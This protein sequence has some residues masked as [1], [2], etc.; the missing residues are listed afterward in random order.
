MKKILLTIPF[1]LTFSNAL[2]ISKS[3][4]FTINSPSKNMNSN[5]SLDYNAKTSE[6]IET[7]FKK[8]IDIVKKGKICK[9]GKYSIYPNYYYE[10][11]KRVQDGYRSTMNFNCEFEDTKNYEN[12]LS[13]I[14][15]LN[16]PLRQGRLN[17]TTTQEIKNK[18]LLKLEEEAFL[19]A[20]NYSDFLNKQ[21]KNCSVKS[22]DLNNNNYH[23]PV[24]REMSLAKSNTQVTAP[25]KEDIKINLSA[26]FKFE[27]DIKKGEN[28]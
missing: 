6:Q 19:Y 21:F 20:K 9:G 3:K 5:F 4:S 18:Y 17:Y 28:R 23:E 25:I 8:A 24:Y 1:I 26:N 7:Q 11:N 10:N 22:I 12:I 16:I 13:K 14:K 15:Q 2:E 27:C